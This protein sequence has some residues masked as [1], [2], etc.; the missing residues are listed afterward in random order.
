LLQA[1][2]WNIPNLFLREEQGLS[3]LSAPLFMLK[4]AKLSLSFDKLDAFVLN[5]FPEFVP[6]SA[7]ESFIADI[8]YQR[9]SVVKDLVA[10]NRKAEKKVEKKLEK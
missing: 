7:L 1:V 5:F 4:R 8:Q 2:F 10:K 9:E 3:G 6:Q